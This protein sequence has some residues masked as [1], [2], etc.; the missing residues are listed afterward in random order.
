[1]VLLTPVQTWLFSRDHERNGHSRP[2]ARF[3]LSLAVVWLFPI[4]LLWFA[5]T[6]DGKTSY[7]SPLVA[8]GVLGF[9]EAVISLSMLNYVTGEIPPETS[10]LALTPSRFISGRRCIS[11]CR[12]YDSVFCPCRRTH[13]PRHANDTWCDDQMGHGD[14]W[15]HFLRIM[16]L[17]LC[18]IFFWG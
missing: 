7:W 3:L 13:P 17:G 8:G 10:K 16:C 12:L 6:C 5:F 2:E 15:I 4:S 11:D 1:M 14:Y 9:V 18:S